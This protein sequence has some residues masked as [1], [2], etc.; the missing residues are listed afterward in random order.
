MITIFI[1]DVTAAST[2][3]P[4]LPERA[5]RRDRNPKELTE[6]GLPIRVA[7]GCA[8]L[9]EEE[10]RGVSGRELQE[11]FLARVLA[12]QILIVWH[13]MLEY[14]VSG[15]IL[16]HTRGGLDSHLTVKHAEVLAPAAGRLT[17]GS[18]VRLP[19]TG[20]ISR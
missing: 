5:K 3:S 8:R 20:P 15:G 16:R 17:L 7:D 12:V 2:D 13:V 18:K 1:N 10:A 11:L 6:P 14:G 9:A 4:L 19:I